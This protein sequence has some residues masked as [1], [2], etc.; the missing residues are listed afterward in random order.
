MKLEDRPDSGIRLSWI[1][2]IDGFGFYVWGQPE[3]LKKVLQIRWYWQA[4]GGVE[5]FNIPKA[6][7]ER[8][9]DGVAF[10]NGNKQE[11]WAGLDVEDMF[12]AICMGTSKDEIKE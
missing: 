10:L 2:E 9:T 3:K 7:I 4:V 12:N 8:V 5:R 6:I 11:E 1:T